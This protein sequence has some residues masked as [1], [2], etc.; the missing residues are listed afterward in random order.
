[1][2]SVFNSES[3]NNNG[4]ILPSLG[5]GIRYTVFEASHFNV[6]LDAAVA[7]NDWGIYFRISEAF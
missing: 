1:V 7:K 3:E 4:K 2:G 5:A 6:G